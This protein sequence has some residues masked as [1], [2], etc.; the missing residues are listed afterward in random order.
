MVERRR[1]LY[2]GTVQGV[3]FR[4]TAR[5][6]AQ[7]Y[8]VSGFVRNLANGKV[9][10]VVEGEPGEIARFLAQIGTDLG[11]YIEDT[12]TSKEAATGKYNGFEIASS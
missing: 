12:A 6:V 9:E 11:H 4:A 8:T 7:S 1:V 3:G 2:S 10:V 5:R